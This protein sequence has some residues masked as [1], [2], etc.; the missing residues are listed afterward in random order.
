[1]PQWEL[2]NSDLR[3]EIGSKP[4]GGAAFVAHGFGLADFDEGAGIAAAGNVFG[5]GGFVGGDH[6]VKGGGGVGGELAQIGIEGDFG[7]AAFLAVVEVADGDFEV[8]HFLKTHGLGAEL[9][10]VGAMGF[11]FATFVFDRHHALRGA[12]EI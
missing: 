1:M 10:F 12:F 4:R 5:G 7:A 3:F 11:G 9:D 6:G 8:E 2:G